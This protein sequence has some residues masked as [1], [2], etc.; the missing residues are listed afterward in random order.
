L[1]TANSPM[2]CIAAHALTYVNNLTQNAPICTT[3]WHDDIQD[4]QDASSPRHHSFRRQVSRWMTQAVRR[5]R[6]IQIKLYLE[7]RAFRWTGSRRSVPA[8]GQTSSR[9]NKLGQLCQRPGRGLGTEHQ[10]SMSFGGQTGRR[11]RGRVDRGDHALG[12]CVGWPGA[13]LRRG[14]H[15]W[16]RREWQEALRLL[17]CGAFSNVRIGSGWP[18]L[19]AEHGKLMGAGGFREFIS[20]RFA[21]R[22]AGRINGK[23]A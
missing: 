12:L 22:L 16:P 6:I 8:V 3:C 2:I 11:D 5:S 15:A 17:P 23:R 9:R 21:E 19:Y 4:S 20:V 18:L 10:S 1:I 13:C 14:A 7:V